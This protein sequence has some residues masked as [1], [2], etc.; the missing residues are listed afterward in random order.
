MSVNQYT[1]VTEALEGLRRRGYTANFE[2][3]GDVLRDSARRR[4]YAASD[5]T[6]VEHHRFEGAS[7]PDDMAIVYAIEGRDGARG[8]LVA[9]FGP[10][11]EPGLGR[12]LDRMTVHEH[13]P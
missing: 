3:T 1:S 8:V 2:F 6:I 13:A 4:Q 9:A 11:A 12:F 7:D 5:L 10:Y